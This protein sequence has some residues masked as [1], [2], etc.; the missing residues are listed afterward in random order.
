MPEVKESHLLLYRLCFS[1]C[2][3]LMLL[4]MIEAGSYLVLRHMG[5]RH[6]NEPLMYE[7]SIYQ[8]KPWAQ[9]YWQEASEARKFSYSSYVVW[10]QLPFSGEMV[11]VEP[12]QRRKT[13]NSTCGTDAYTIWMFG[14]STMFATGSPDWGTIPSQ[15]AGLFAKAGVPVCVRNFG[16]TGWRNTQEVIELILELKSNPRRPNLVVF[17]DGYNEGYAFDQSGKIDVH[18]NYDRIREQIE[19]PSRPRRGGFV[20]DFLLS[21]HTGR[22]ITGASRPE[23]ALD[24]YAVPAPTRT[25]QADAKSDLEIAYLRNLD[26]VRA[27]ASEYGFQYAFFWQPVIFA[28]H[29]PLTDEEKKIRRFFSSGIYESDVQYREISSRL[30]SGVTPH[31]FD[32]SDVFDHCPQTLYIDYV[33]IG[34]EGNGIVARRM[35]DVLQQ[36]GW[37]PPTAPTST[38]AGRIVSHRVA[39]AGQPSAA[40]LRQ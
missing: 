29:K 11:T 32:I 37:L 23:T 16:Q 3:T 39:L 1:C 10:R 13:L 38:A 5:G 12:D 19:R 4:V 33:H 26:V 40:Q 30:R 36:A 28:G 15:L 21:T 18:M 8:G 6:T 22:L 17:Y 20:L 7:S 31:L 14:G 25:S 34:P 9:Q 27:L 24:G 2:F 35:Y